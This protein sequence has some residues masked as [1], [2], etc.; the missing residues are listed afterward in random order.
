MDVYVPDP[1]PVPRAGVLLLHG[2]GWMYGDRRHMRPLARYLA[3]MGYTAA[4]ASYR[5]CNEAVHHP[6]PVQDA[7]AAVKFLR[8]SAGRFDID[9]GR[10]A[11]GGYSAGGQLALL[12]GLARDPTI[13]GDDSYPGVSPRVQAIIDMSGPARLEDIYHSGHWLL[14]RMGRAYLGGSPEEFPDRYKDASPLNHVRAGAPPVL[15]LHG[16]RDA[17]VPWRHAELIRA[18]LD[19]VGGTCVLARLPGFAHDWCLPLDRGESLRAMPILTQFL[20]CHLDEQAA[21]GRSPD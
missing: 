16:D 11:V 19:R 4:T 1:G 18:A 9:P 15:I 7:V 14:Q 5:L 10:I 12:V 8:A 6:V 13:F 21:A 3:S 17:V 2:G 20:A